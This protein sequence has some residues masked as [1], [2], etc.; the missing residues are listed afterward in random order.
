MQLRKISLLAAAAMF[1]Y[2]AT[3]AQ[4][5]N[6]LMLKKG[7]KYTVENK[8]STYSTTEVQGQAM[9]ATIEA[10]TSY[11]IEV[12]DNKDKVY[13]LTN[14]VKNVKMEMSQMGQEISFD[15][16]KKEDLDG[17]IGSAL[18]DYINV[19]QKVMISNEGDI[20]KDAAETSDKPASPFG[21]FGT[22]GFGA[23]LAFQAVPKNLKVGQ[24][25]KNTSNENGTVKNT[26]YT[27]KSVDGNLATLSLAGDMDI[28]VKMEQMG[29]EMTTKAKGTFTGEEVVDVKTG[30]VQSQN[31]VVNSDGTIEVMG[32]ELPTSS[33]VTS[34]TTV[35]AI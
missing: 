18:K 23:A 17:P 7:Q 4:A 30:V 10:T 34:T 29:M 12:S 15:S 26:T 24:T 28:N 14:T 2:S 9:E 20:I 1:T 33:K 25:W 21:D 22:G 27:V 6:N 5:N 13:N 3:I 8:T 32:Q 31:M 19:P 16:D 11:Q 35:K